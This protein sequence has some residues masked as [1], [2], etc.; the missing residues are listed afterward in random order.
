MIATSFRCGAVLIST[1]AGLTAGSC[2]FGNDPAHSYRIHAGSTT[3]GGDANQQTRRLNRILVHP[4]YSPAPN[5]R[6]DI[7][8]LYWTVPLEAG[9]TVRAIS[10]PPQGAAVP[11]GKS[12]NVLGWGV[13]RDAAGELDADVL[14]VATVPLVTNEVCNQPDSY[15]GVI[16]PEMLCAGLPKG[17]RGPCSRDW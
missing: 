8:I 14:Q 11:Y 2:K 12:C 3:S 10:L 7:A 4:K 1:T 9:P 13:L 6:N 17:G 16:Q 15:N 5:L